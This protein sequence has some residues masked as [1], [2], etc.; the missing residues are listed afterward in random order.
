MKVYDVYIADMDALPVRE[1][2]EHDFKSKIDNMHH[3]CVN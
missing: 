3:A 2:T 1:L